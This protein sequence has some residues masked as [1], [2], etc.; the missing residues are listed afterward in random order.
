MTLFRGGDKR[1]LTADL[2]NAIYIKRVFACCLLLPLD[3]KKAFSINGYS[4]LPVVS[5]CLLL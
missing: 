2:L 4:N 5:C 1:D 3:A